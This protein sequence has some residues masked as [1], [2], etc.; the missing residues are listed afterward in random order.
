M[1][2]SGALLSRSSDVD[3]L[4]D[5]DLDFLNVHGEGVD[6]DDHEGMM[7]GI[8]D[9]FGAEGNTSKCSMIGGGEHD[10]G[11]ITDGTGDLEFNECS[12]NS[13]VSSSRLPTGIV[14]RQSLMSNEDHQVHRTRANSL[15]FPGMLL[16]GANPDDGAQ[17]SFGQWM[18]KTVP[19]QPH[20]IQI[21]QRMPLV[22]SVPKEQ[23]LFASQTVDVNRNQNILMP[24]QV[25]SE[26][27]NLMAS[28]SRQ[29]NSYLATQIATS[30]S[31]PKFKK[32]K[33]KKNPSSKK[34]R[35]EPRERKSHSKMKGMMESINGGGNATSPTLTG[36]D[37]DTKGGPTSGQGR[38]RS[39]S[40]PSL[41]VRLDDYGLLHV[42]GPEGW[43]GAYSP[44]SRQLR[45][46]RYMEKRS[47]RVFKKVVKYDVRKNFADSRLRVKGRF[48]KKEDEMLM[49]ELMSLT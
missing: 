28:N 14:N 5:L 37:N 19:L 42:N 29:G 43:V 10:G 6:D 13:G 7:F 31:K 26:C 25:S 12:S 34:E 20:K 47:H 17:I 3:L 41:S 30:S 21:S 36:D 39:M 16:D 49:R 1:I 32:E 38:P 4:G 22:T 15:A 18:D 40:D 48:V 23:K 33:V 46:R 8:M 24:T 11:P 35:K 44:D 27:D 9:D 45:I 2:R